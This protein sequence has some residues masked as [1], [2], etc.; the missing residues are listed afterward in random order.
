MFQWFKYL[1]YVLC[2]ALAAA[3]LYPVAVSAAPG[4]LP[5]NC[6][7]CDLANANL[8]GRDLRNVSWVGVDLNG[9]DLR[10]ADLRGAHLV[11]ADL[12]HV[13]LTGARIGGAK[14]VGADISDSELPGMNF[15]NTGL[16]GADFKH[17]NLEGSSFA[18]DKLIGADFDH[19]MLRNANFSGTVLCV[20]GDD[21]RIGCSQFNGADL[22]GADFHGAQLCESNT[23]TVRSDDDRTSTFTRTNDGDERGEHDFANCRPL[24]AGMLRSE[25]HADLSGA[26]GI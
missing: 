2:A 7:G 5:S 22:R 10:N 1:S 15:S 13:R 20:R 18:G 17:S 23:I 24:D 9:A 11:G 26:R 8:Q 16:V 21:G 3:P 14:L 12:K 19:A 25:G 4:A 6:V